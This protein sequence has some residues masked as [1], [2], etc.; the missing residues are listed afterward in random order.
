MAQDAMRLTARAQSL[1]ARI[2]E[3]FKARD[4]HT[5][6]KSK[7]STV[8]HWHEGAHPYAT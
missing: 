8:Y 4:F 6:E 2:D 1:L 5:I 3:F 7:A